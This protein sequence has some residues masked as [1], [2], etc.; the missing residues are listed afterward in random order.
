M[1]HKQE[2]RELIK[3]A[4]YFYQ[5]ANEEQLADSLIEQ[6]HRCLE[7]N[8]LQDALT[9]FEE[10]NQLEKWRDVYGTLVLANLAYICAKLGNIL[11]AKDY[12]YDYYDLY[13]QGDFN[14]DP[15]EYHKLAFVHKEIDRI[16]IE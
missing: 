15:D 4:L 10:A 1:P 8:K 3:T 7:E 5:I 12:L 14:N 6:G 2:M 16:D 9:L 11:R 13:G